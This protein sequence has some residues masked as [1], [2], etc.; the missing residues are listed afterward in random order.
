[1]PAYAPHPAELYQRTMFNPYAAA[2]AAAHSQAFAGAPGSLLPHSHFGG[3]MPHAYNP[4]LAAQSHAV[5][6]NLD[7]TGAMLAHHNNMMES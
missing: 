4:H 1:M 6:W 7:P 5:T 3:M 2:A